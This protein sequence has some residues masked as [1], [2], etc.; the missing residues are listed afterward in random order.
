MPEVYHIWE[1]F[2][3]DTTRFVVVATSK[4]DVINTLCNYEEDF[5]T[6]YTDDN[7]FLPLDG[8]TLLGLYT[9]QPQQSHVRGS[10]FNE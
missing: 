5:N 10:F 3:R 6:L 9:G 8:I 4:Q 7:N 1:V 2:C